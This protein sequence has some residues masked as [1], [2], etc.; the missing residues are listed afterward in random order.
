[1]P[2]CASYFLRSRPGKPPKTAIRPTDRGGNIPSSPQPVQRPNAAGGQAP[3]AGAT[4]QHRLSINA[5]DDRVLCSHAPLRAYKPV[6]SVVGAVRGDDVALGEQ[7]YP[8]EL[9]GHACD[10]AS[11]RTSG[12]LR[13]RYKRVRCRHVVLLGDMEIQGDSPHGFLHLLRSSAVSAVVFDYLFR[14]ASPPAPGRDG[15][16]PRR[17]CSRAP[18]RGRR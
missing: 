12:R 15:R 3:H 10:P 7:P 17:A 6:G 4:D 5:I 18:G 16:W 13:R 2:F 1:M 11:G 8:G 9:L 14:V